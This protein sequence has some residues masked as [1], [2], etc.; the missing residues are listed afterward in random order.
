M[1]HLVSKG[2]TQPPIEQHTNKETTWKQTATKTPLKYCGFQVFKTA[3]PFFGIHFWVQ[4]QSKAW[5]LASPKRSCFFAPHIAPDDVP[6]WDDHGLLPQMSG[7]KSLER[8][9]A[10]ESNVRIHT[11]KW[12]GSSI[13]IY[14]SWYIRGKRADLCLRDVNLYVN[15]WGK[16]MVCSGFK[17]SKPPTQNTRN[18]IGRHYP[19]TP[20]FNKRYL[21]P[22]G[23]ELIL[24]DFACL[25]E[26]NTHIYYYYISI[27][28]PDL[29]KI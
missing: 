15:T 9:F 8:N 6:I 22:S 26:K 27:H 7:W 17:L 13:Y 14:I 21:V 24:L 5:R 10:G 28:F 20:R 16:E 1:V 19:Q 29:K 3:S 11:C 4:S 23:Y 25:T 18:I 2:L 12:I